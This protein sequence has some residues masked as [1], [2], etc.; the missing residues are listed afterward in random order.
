MSACKSSQLLY[1][2]S[3][4]QYRCKVSKKKRRFPKNLNISDLLRDDKEG[5]IM[6]IIN[7]YYF[8]NWAFFMGNP[9]YYGCSFD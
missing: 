6:Q 8:R 4:G 7:F 3:I 1:S 2:Q 9:V 5:K